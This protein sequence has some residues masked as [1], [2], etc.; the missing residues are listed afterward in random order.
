MKT[1]IAVLTLIAVTAGMFTYT[2]PLNAMPSGLSDA[3]ADN[4]KFDTGIPVFDKAGGDIP[5]PK[6]KAVDGP[7][8]LF[9]I[10]SPA[11]ADNG[12]VQNGVTMPYYLMAPRPAYTAQ[13]AGMYSG[14]PVLL[15]HAIIPDKESLLK[16]VSFWN[17]LLGNA[18]V[19][20]QSLKARALP[21]GYTLEIL[22]IGGPAIKSF[23]SSSAGLVY[24]TV[25]DA[26]KGAEETTS[27]IEAAGRKVLA[28]FTVRQGDKFSFAVYFK[29]IA[30]AE[31]TMFKSMDMVDAASDIYAIVEGAHQVGAVFSGAASYFS[32][33]ESNKSDYKGNYKS[34]EKAVNAMIADA[35]RRSTVVGLEIYTNEKPEGLAY[36]YLVYWKGAGF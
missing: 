35:E 5:E 2:R 20:L 34:A 9:G 27:Q 8:S 26:A 4:G 33:T 13:E 14:Y 1:K 30:P 28:K 19:K 21:S 22:Y 29:S 17:G 25:A 15:S 3:V 16:A 31:E 11:S 18:G 36:S 32:N 12:I 24:T 7:K 23:D 6:A 10:F